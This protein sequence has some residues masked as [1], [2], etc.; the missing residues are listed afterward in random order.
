MA[1]PI[2]RSTNFFHNKKSKKVSYENLVR[3][4]QLFFY[5]MFLKLLLAD[6]AAIFVTTPLQ[7]IKLIL[8]IFNNWGLPLYPPNLL[9]LLLLFNYGK[10]VCK[11][12][13]IDLMDNFKEPLLSKSIT[14]F[15]RRWHISLS[16]WFKDYLYI[17]L[18]GNRKGSFRKCLNL[19]IVFLVSGLWHGAELS[20]VLWGLIHGVFNVM[21]SL[22]GINKNNKSNISWTSL[23]EFDPTYCCLCLYLL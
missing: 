11:N 22:L 5:G 12:S 23:G 4:L 21:E 7:I 8:G 1:G 19:L 10:G 15:W 17:P 18:G 13:G 2:E 14:E 9:R 3:G 16:T 6:R 20:F